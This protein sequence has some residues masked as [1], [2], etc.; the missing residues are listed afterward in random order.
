MPLLRTYNVEDSLP[1]LDEAGRLVMAQIREAKRGG[2][3]NQAFKGG[4]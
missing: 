3:L 2:I 4:L 1:S